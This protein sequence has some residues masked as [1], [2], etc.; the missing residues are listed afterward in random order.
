MQGSP[1]VTEGQKDPTILGT[2]TATCKTS[3]NE[4]TFDA[5]WG[6]DVSMN[7]I[8]CLSESLRK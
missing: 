2:V 7:G 1:Q 5:D 3:D 8:G 6:D 4:E